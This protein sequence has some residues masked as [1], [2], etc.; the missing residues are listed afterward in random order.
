MDIV[1][2]IDMLAKQKGWSRSEVLRRIDL[3]PSAPQGWRNNTASPDK[4][5]PKLAVILDTT[6][7]YLRGETDDPEP[8]KQSLEELGISAMYFRMAKK[9]Q[10]YNIDPRDLETIIELVK[11][12][13][14]PNPDDKD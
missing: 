11:K 8:H 10:E 6:E 5:I 4:H 14:E 9:A 12:R 3:S 2:R 13:H 7:A 1:D